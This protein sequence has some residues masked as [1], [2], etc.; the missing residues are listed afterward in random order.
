MDRSPYAIRDAQARAAERYA[1]THSD[2]PDVPDLLARLR[3]AR[4]IYLRWGRETL[5]WSLYL[6][7]K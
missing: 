2:D 7:G 5:G 6:F 1:A 4:D 3:R